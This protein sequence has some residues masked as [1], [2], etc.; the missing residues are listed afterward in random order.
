MNIQVD[1]IAFKA[2]SGN[3]SNK[4]IISNTTSEKPQLQEESFD[5]RALVSQNE[6]KEGHEDSHVADAP[7]SDENISADSPVLT[8]PKEEHYLLNSGQ[9]IKST[10]LSA[11]LR[12]SINVQTN[13]AS[14][15]DELN[16]ESAVALEPFTQDVLNPQ[17]QTSD[18]EALAS[19]QAHSIFENIQPTTTTKDPKIQI[20]KLENNV[21]ATEVT[22]NLNSQGFAPMN[23][24][25]NDPERIITQAVNTNLNMSTS[26]S[27]N[28]SGQALT[29]QLLS[30]FLS[31]GANTDGANTGA[32]NTGAANT[33]A[34]KIADV[35][36]TQQLG[37]SKNELLNLSSS[38]LS[39]GVFARDNSEG[40]T[41]KTQGLP[42]AQ[43]N[44]LPADTFEWRQE[45]LQ[46]TTSEW[47]QRLLNVLGDKVNLQIG[48]QLQRAQI[49]LDP[50]HLG[51]IEISINIEGDKTSVNLMTNNAQVREAIAQTLDQLRQ[52][53]SQSG[54][55]TIDLGFSE[56][57]QH[58]QGA[59]KSENTAEI[60]DNFSFSEELELDGEMQ[61]GSSS[62]W[63]NRLV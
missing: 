26:S 48:Q 51:R 36:S 17:L 47:G 62:D 38:Q 29:S 11:G 33:G 1:N 56:Q 4:R 25:S 15:S 63:L 14:D 23:L 13:L 10:E 43:N 16:A 34:T 27:A 41:V 54:S 8:E 6:T 61:Q 20:N 55:V 60:A 58:E 32:V 44:N 18:S 59:P 45:K 19:S 21:L 53:L 9:R 5:G 31:G 7:S 49:R 3:E 57:H 37:A 2:Q 35:I 46:G 24:V 12:G 40:L 30:R 52:T 39:T 28:S 42:L 50:P 22:A